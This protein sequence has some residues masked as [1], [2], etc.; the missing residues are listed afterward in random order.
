[1]DIIQPDKDILRVVEGQSVEILDQVDA[2]EVDLAP[3]QTAIAI[4]SSHGQV[5]IHLIAQVATIE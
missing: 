3:P 5:E 1:M 2:T 4:K